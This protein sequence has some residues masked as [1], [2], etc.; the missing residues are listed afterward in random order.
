LTTVEACVGDVENVWL[1]RRDSVDAKRRTNFYTP[2]SCFG[3]WKS[4]GWS[5]SFCLLYT[6]TGYRR[7]DMALC[8]RLPLHTEWQN[9]R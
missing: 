1:T 4:L 2:S 7:K 8:F 3:V 5:S 6:R 9:S